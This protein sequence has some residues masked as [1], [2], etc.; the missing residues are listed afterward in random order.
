[1]DCGAYVV[2]G[3]AI[4][5]MN[6]IT[7]TADITNEH[8]DVIVPKGTILNLEDGVYVGRSTSTG[9]TIIMDASW[10]DDEVYMEFWSKEGDE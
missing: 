9:L 3:F 1:M 10:V 7:A 6:R 8:D 2:V 4:E 5:T